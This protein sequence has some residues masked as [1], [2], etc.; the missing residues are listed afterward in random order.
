MLHLCLHSWKLLNPTASSGWSVAFW[1]ISY[2]CSLRLMDDLP[3]KSNPELYF[4]GGFLTKC[5]SIWHVHFVVIRQEN[6]EGEDMEI[7]RINL[8]L[9]KATAYVHLQSSVMESRRPTPFKYEQQ[10]IVWQ[11]ISCWLLRIQRTERET[12]A[13]TEV[14]EKAGIGDVEEVRIV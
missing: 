14:A 8:K 3:L 7:I 2:S 1:C 12:E 5:C 6:D 11:I 4:Y 13:V 10:A 9:E